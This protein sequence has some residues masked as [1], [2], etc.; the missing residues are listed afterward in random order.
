MSVWMSFMDT[1]EELLKCLSTTIHVNL[2]EI[3][4]VGGSVKED[5]AGEVAIRIS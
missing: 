4:G 2:I 5:E 1:L 3:Y